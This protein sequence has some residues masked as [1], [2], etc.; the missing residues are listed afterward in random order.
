MKVKYSILLGLSHT[1]VDSTVTDNSDVLF[2]IST[3][4]EETNDINNAKVSIINS[5]IIYILFVS[6][7]T[8]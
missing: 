7:T 8:W 6:W 4:A 2:E 1:T 3:F 5:F